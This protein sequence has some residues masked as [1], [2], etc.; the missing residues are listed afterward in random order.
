MVRLGMMTVH[1]CQLL[2][3]AGR[4]I[5]ASSIDPLEVRAVQ[6]VL[7]PLEGFYDGGPS[8]DDKSD[9]QNCSDDHFFNPSEEMHRG[10]CGHTGE[11]NFD[12]GLIV[13]RCDIFA[14]P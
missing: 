2:V 10:L 4:R 12:L 8:G 14:A 1:K 5:M 11:W 7:M 3:V 13:R 6:N 9:K